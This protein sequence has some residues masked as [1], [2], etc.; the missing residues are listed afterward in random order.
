MACRG[1]GLCRCLAATATR[2]MPARRAV[3]SADS[4]SVRHHHGSDRKP[5]PMPSTRARTVVLRDQ[6]GD[7]A[8]PGQEPEPV[9][10][11]GINGALRHRPAWG[12][13]EPGAQDRGARAPDRRPSAADSPRARA[14]SRTRR[15]ASWLRPRRSRAERWRRRGCAARQAIPTVDGIPVEPVAA[16]QPRRDEERGRYRPLF[17][18][19]AER[20]DVG[21]RLLTDAG[22]RDDQ[23]SSHTHIVA[24]PG[25]ATVSDTLPAVVYSAIAAGPPRWPRPPRARPVRCADGT[26]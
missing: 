23:L 15:V 5:S 26:A 6:V 4:T 7:S 1:P 20:L 13:E 10:R 3:R 8:Q 22:D 25:V 24:T 11:Q 18:L 21:Q 16:L 17:Q 9:A 12:G 19:C 2:T 14:A